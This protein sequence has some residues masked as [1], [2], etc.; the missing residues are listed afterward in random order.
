MKIFFIYTQKG[1]TATVPGPDVLSPCEVIGHGTLQ[2]GE[3]YLVG[4]GGM[5]E[6]HR[7]WSP[8][9]EYTDK[10]LRYLK[11]LRDSDCNA[12]V[13]ISCSFPLVLSLSLLPV[14]LSRLLLLPP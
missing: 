13:D 10:E 7:T 14:L 1:D 8:V 6:A 3:S 5:C 12:G 2:Y 4:I 9:S 11:S